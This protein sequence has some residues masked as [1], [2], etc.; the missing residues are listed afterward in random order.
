MK[1]MSNFI[2]LVEFQKKTG[3]SRGSVYWKIKTG[4]LKEGVDFKRIPVKRLV[5]REDLKI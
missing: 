3:K 2:T 5:V 1:N 4:Q